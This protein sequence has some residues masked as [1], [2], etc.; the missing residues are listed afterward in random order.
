MLAH[1]SNSSSDYFP[2][3][4]EKSAGSF[5]TE[6][7]LTR[8]SKILLVTDDQETV[9]LVEKSLQPEMDVQTVSCSKDGTK[10]L[11][12]NCPDLILCDLKSEF[13]D[14]R[15]ALRKAEFCDIPFLLFSPTQKRKERIR[16]LM[17]GVS[18]IVLKPCEAQELLARVHFHLEKYKAKKYLQKQLQ[19][20]SA[21]LDQLA[22]EIALK[23]QELSRLNKLKDEFLAVLSHELRNPMNVISGYAELLATEEHQSE[24]TRL[25]ADAIYR[26]A[27]IQIR[28]VDELSDIAKGIAGKLVLDCKPMEIESLLQD[29]LPSARE[30]AEKKRIHLNVQQSSHLGL[31]NGDSA[32]MSQV[33]WNL[34][35]NALKFTPDGGR[36]DV[37]IDRKDPWIEFSVK[38]SGVG[39]DPDF[40]PDIFEK[41][42][43]QDPTITKKFGGLGLGLSIVHHI[44]ELHG[45]TVQASSDGIGHGATFLVRI[46][47]LPN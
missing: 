15:T 25:A 4:S 3:S 32:R 9:F 1:T 40:L 45:G 30:A 22:E 7:E 47:A 37:S 14:L 26:N 42:H 36:I 44:V 23:N 20:S 21:P 39:I 6:T 16:M 33:I 10:M 8:K 43:Q 31:I 12:Q 17:D 24:E 11:D 27:Q 41:F 19:K 34:F 46:P 35:S 13:E 38:D 28:L 2:R 5:S 18:D 29:L